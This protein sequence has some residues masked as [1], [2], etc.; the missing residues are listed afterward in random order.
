MSAKCWEV[1]HRGSFQRSLSKFC[2]GK[3]EE[4]GPKA[5]TFVLLNSMECLLKT[6]VFPGVETGFTS[7]RNIY[8]PRFFL[9]WKQGLFLYVTSISLDW[10]PRWNIARAWVST[11]KGLGLVLLRRRGTLR[12]RLS[13]DWELETFPHLPSACSFIALFSLWFASEGTW[14]KLSHHLAETQTPALLLSN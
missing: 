7:V 6:T 3:Q 13:S 1:G 14:V 10:S 4:K 11:A 12:Q 8:F 9:V 5:S 2:L